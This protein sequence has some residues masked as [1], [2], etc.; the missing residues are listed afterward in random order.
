MSG[1]LVS[2]A[3]ERFRIAF[4]STINKVVILWC[5]YYYLTGLLCLIVQ[6]FFFG[7]PRTSWS[8]IPVKLA[9]CEIVQFNLAV[10]GEGLVFKAEA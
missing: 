3:L 4:S 7:S 5:N 8:R 2:S 1:Q 9:M 6:K 10:H